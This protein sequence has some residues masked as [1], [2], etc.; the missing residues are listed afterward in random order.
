MHKSDKWTLDSVLLNIEVTEI[1]L[2]EKIKE[3]P[4]DG[5]YIHGIF[6]EGAAW[7]IPESSLVESQHKQLFA[8]LPILHV[9][10]IT[11]NQRKA[12]GGNFGAYGGYECPLYKYPIRTDKYLIS[13]VTLATNE[14]TP[15]HWA[16]RGTAMLCFID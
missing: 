10:A 14:Q 11:K 7:S 9:S 1:S 2:L 12:M 16:L 8:K 3:Y 15:E 5:L 6:L 13:T 4:R